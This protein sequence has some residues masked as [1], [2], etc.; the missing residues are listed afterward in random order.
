MLALGMALM[1]NP[2]LMLLDEPSLGLAPA[3]VNQVFE[4][5]RGLCEREGIAVLLV[6]QQVRAAL[7]IADYVYFLRL[8]RIAHHETVAEAASRPD[9][10]SLF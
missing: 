10:W 1:G 3:L 4:V 9:Y 2:R 6:E 5:I 7:E 8:G